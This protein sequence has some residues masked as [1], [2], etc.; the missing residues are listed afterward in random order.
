[1]KD[2]INRI[3]KGKMA[4]VIYENCGGDI[5]EKVFHIDPFLSSFFLLSFFLFSGLYCMSFQCPLLLTLQCVRVIGG[6]GRLLV[7][8]FASGTIPSFPINLALVKGFSLVGVRSGAEM[9]LQPN[10]KKVF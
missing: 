7:V 9:M 1:M 8:G 5:F 3:T 6:G 2:E 4:D 10:L